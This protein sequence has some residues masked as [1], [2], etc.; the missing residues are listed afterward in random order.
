MGVKTRTIRYALCW[1]SGPYGGERKKSAASR[2]HVACTGRSLTVADADAGLVLA[3]PPP[4]VDCVSYE[5]DFLYNGAR[6][7][8]SQ[9]TRLVSR[10]YLQ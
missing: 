2:Q 10:S 1:E 5:A 4:I 7:E 8:Q 9:M 3:V 6:Q